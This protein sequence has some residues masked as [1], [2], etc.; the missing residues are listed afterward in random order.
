MQIT[1]AFTSDV[2]VSLLG[3]HKRGFSWFYCHWKSRQSG[4]PPH[5]E[6]S[7]KQC[8]R[9]GNKLPKNKYYGQAPARVQTHACMRHFKKLI[10]GRDFRILGFGG[11]WIF[12]WVGAPNL[13][14][15]EVVTWRSN[16]SAMPHACTR[17]VW[18][19]KWGVRPCKCQHAG[20]LA[21]LGLPLPLERIQ[22]SPTP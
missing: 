7:K 16:W 5:G 14:L 11:T 9:L 3:G 19:T 2:S 4:T 10:Y 20:L 8:P 12:A 13:D 17:A 6:Q 21:L 18:C 22:P 15:E 1:S